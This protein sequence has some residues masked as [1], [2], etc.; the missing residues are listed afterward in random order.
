VIGHFDVTDFLL[1][2]TDDLRKLAEVGC[3]L[4]VVAV[5][6]T[7]LGTNLLTPLALRPT[8]PVAGGLFHSGKRVAHPATRDN[9]DWIAVPEWVRI[10]LERARVAFDW[11]FFALFLFMCCGTLLA[12][13]GH[14]SVFES[15]WDSGAYHR[16]SGAIVFGSLATLFALEA[17]FFRY[18][19]LKRRKSVRPVFRS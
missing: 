1:R 15:L 11:I 7:C 5:V 8:I 14:P 2:H 9:P 19:A 4:S 13:I 3:A 18:G 17:L 12:P 10:I 6:S 16:L